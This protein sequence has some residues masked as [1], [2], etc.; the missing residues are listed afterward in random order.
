MT[1]LRSIDNTNAAT[2]SVE[3]NWPQHDQLTALN[4]AAATLQPVGADEARVYLL[5]HSEAGVTWGVL[6]AGALA[7]SPGGAANMADTV[8]WRAYLFSQA[9]EIYAWRDSSGVWRARAI[10]GGAQNGDVMLTDSYD[11]EYVLWG[12]HPSDAGQGFESFTRLDDGAQ[13]LTHC[14]PIAIPARD[15][16]Y[17]LHERPACLRVRHYVSYDAGTGAASI[18]VS[19]L[20][21]LY[22]RPVGA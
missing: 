11:E 4:A 1:P 12:N 20:V 5:A 19:R 15:Q 8:L 7:L 18:C 9:G 14:V 22:A 13:G 16:G 10:R 17:E 3:H 2:M 6:H 21:D